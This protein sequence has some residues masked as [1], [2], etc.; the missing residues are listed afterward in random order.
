M[1]HYGRINLLLDGDAAGRSFTRMARVWNPDKY[2]DRSDFYQGRKDL[3]EW[4]IHEFLQQPRIRQSPR[5]GR[6]I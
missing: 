2:I 4:L 5:K 1:E 3:N 6:S